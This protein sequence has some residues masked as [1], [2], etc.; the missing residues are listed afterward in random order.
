MTELVIGT[1]TQLTEEPRRCQCVCHDAR[2]GHWRAHL[3][4]HCYPN[5][6]RRDKP[7]STPR[8]TPNKEPTRLTLGRTRSTQR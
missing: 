1:I 8:T 2:D 5:F 6:V 7:Q 4:E 3:C